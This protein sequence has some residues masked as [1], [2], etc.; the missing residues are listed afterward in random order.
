M[1]RL[2]KRNHLQWGPM[3]CKPHPREAFVWSRA[4]GLTP[5]GFTDM[6]CCLSTQRG[7]PGSRGLLLPP[8]TSGRAPPE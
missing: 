4:D 3:G 1:L 8:E 6:A 5:H 7:R 2:S